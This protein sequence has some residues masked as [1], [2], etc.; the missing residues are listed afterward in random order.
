MIIGILFILAGILIVLYPPLL[1]LIVALFLMFI[2]LSLILMHFYF[3]RASREFNNPF[4][5]FFI[6][7]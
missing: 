6:R 7:F 1:S 2:G 3:R 4:M 5:N